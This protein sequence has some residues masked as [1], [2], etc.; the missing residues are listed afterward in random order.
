MW[1]TRDNW[2]KYDTQWSER[3]Y[4]EEGRAY[5][6]EGDYY[7]G[8]GAYFLTLG[9]HKETTNHTKEDVDMA[10]Q[11]QQYLK[12]SSNIEEETQVLKKKKG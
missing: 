6:I 9:L 4:L 7:D 1:Y 3:M 8:G 11:E 10:V 5:Y 12:L 2:N